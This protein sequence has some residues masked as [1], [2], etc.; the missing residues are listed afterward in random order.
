M[1]RNYLP[2]PSA[3]S[4][5]SRSLKRG[6]GARGGE[7][8]NSRT[9]TT[10]ST[11]TSCALLTCPSK[12]VKLPATRVKLRSSLCPP[13]CFLAHFLPLVIAS[14]FLQHP[15]SKTRSK[16]ACARYAPKSTSDNAV[17]AYGSCSS[18]LCAYVCVWMRL[19]M[20]IY[21][22]L[23]DDATG[24]V[25]G[26]LEDTRSKLNDNDNFQTR[27]SHIYQCKKIWKNLKNIS[28]VPRE[29]DKNENWFS[30][31]CSLI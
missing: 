20:G 18:R 11:R 19:V 21:V 16:I 14:F 10:F 22:C 12:S 7:E 3:F 8:E 27:E 6:H 29:I 5:A 15:A 13:C 23:A 28:Y 31:L 9:G 4:W 26:W 25:P 2:V 17:A 30:F 1:S 24:F